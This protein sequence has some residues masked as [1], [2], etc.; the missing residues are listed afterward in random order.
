MLNIRQ[1]QTAVRNVKRIVQSG[2]PQRI[3]QKMF[4]ILRFNPSASSEARVPPEI[5]DI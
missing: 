4:R 5:V 1:R 3:N 2:P